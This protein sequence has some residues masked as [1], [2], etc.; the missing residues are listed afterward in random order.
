MRTIK[1]VGSIGVVVIPLVDNGQT[2]GYADM[3]YMIGDKP[4]RYP[5]PAIVHKVELFHDRVTLWTCC[6]G[7]WSL[8]Y[9]AEIPKTVCR[10]LLGECR[11]CIWPL[12]Q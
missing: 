8:D 5:V 4:P 12:C 3:L 9:L 11:N 1:H 6:A 7:Y 2:L 10:G